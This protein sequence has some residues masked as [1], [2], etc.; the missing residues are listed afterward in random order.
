MRGGAKG[1][2]LYGGAFVDRYYGGEGNDTFF[3][4]M[5]LGSTSTVAP[6]TTRFTSTSGTPSARIASRFS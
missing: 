6:D 3:L 2:T 4:K 5:V 1:D